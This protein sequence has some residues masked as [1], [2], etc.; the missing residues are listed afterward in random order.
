MIEAEM[1]NKI[2][3]LETWEDI[4]T[5]NVFG[6][7]D[8]LN[9]EYLLEIVSNAKNHNNQQ[10]SFKD[11]YV[12]SV[13]LWKNFKNIGEPDI[14]V[15]LDDNSFF[16]I[17][18]KYFSHEHNGKKEIQESED[19][20]QKQEKGQLA[21]YFDIKI[22]NKKSDF[23]IY[24]TQ[25][26]QSLKVIQNSDDKK[27]N[28]KSSLDKIYHIHWNEFNEYLISIKGVDGIKKNIIDKIIEYLNFKG[29][30]YWSG[31]KYRKEY[32]KLKLNIGEFYGE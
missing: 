26:Y 9:N 17:E 31:I 21:K 25:D 1:C 22:D 28:S 14:V 6:L 27:A 19:E 11:R 7:L 18:V 15:T 5:S 12:K 30:R 32:E 16:I 10:I 23:I 4:L 3:K 29:F 24:L 20:E 13:K 2:P 8:L